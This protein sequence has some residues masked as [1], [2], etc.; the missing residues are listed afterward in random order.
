M[1]TNNGTIVRLKEA[2]KWEKLVNLD[3]E[4]VKFYCKCSVDYR[5]GTFKVEPVITLIHDFD[6]NDDQV[7]LEAVRECRAHCNDLLE[8]HRSAM[9]LGRQGNLFEEPE[10]AEA[11]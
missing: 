11:A 1:S 6:E 2:F 7:I 8:N 10:P 9:G 3:G 4:D 5:N